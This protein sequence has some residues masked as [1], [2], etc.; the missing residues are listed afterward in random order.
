MIFY[1]D[2]PVGDEADPNDS[3]RLTS[4]IAFLVGPFEASLRTRLP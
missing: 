2:D 4:T 3:C 1:I